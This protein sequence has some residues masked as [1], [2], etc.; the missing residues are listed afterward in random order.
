VHATHPQHTPPEQAERDGL[1]KRLGSTTKQ[2]SEAAGKAAAASAQADALVQEQQRL[3][4]EV[5]RLS[6]ML[7]S[8]SLR[9]QK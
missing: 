3:K 9:L 2:Q 6:S 5:E 8:H 7:H 1:H 4:S